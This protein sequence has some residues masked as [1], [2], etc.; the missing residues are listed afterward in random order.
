MTAITDGG[1]NVIGIRERT[2]SSRLPNG[3][4]WDSV[5]AVLWVRR[6]RSDRLQPHG[7]VNVIGIRKRTRSSQRGT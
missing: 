7:G 3:G 5:V 6:V 4:G 1:V 2:R